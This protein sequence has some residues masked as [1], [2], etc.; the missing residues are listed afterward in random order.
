[1]IEDDVILP[2]ETFQERADPPVVGHARSRMVRCMNAD[3]GAFKVW[4]QQRCT[5]GV[6]QVEEIPEACPSCVGHL[7]SAEVAEDPLPDG[8]VRIQLTF[9]V[10]RRDHELLESLARDIA[11]VIRRD[12]LG[13]QVPVMRAAGLDPKM[14]VEILG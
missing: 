11:A 8:V 5:E 1:M 10:L 13:A 3:C 2:A 12:F 7:D 6:H 14:E 4:I 9:P